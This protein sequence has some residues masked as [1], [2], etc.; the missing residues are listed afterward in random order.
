MTQIILDAS[1]SSKLNH[2]THSVELS[3]PRD[4]FSAIR[5]PDRRVGMGAALPRRLRGGID[6][7]MPDS[8]R[9]THTTA[10]VLAQLGEAVMFRCD[11]DYSL[12][13]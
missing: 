2:L 12:M 9:E 13:D 1:V 11:W 7:A 3:T 4:G 6:S 8:K 10:E 5:P